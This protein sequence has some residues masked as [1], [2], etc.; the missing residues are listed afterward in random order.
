[1]AEDCDAPL[2]G[3]SAALGLFL[4]IGTLVSYIPQFWIIAKNKSSD[5]INPLAMW[6]NFLSGFLTL[7]N[8]LLLSW[9]DVECCGHT[10]FGHCLARTLPITQLLIGPVC[11]FFLCLFIAMYFDTTA[12]QM[13][14]RRKKVLQRFA[15]WTF[16]WSNVL[17]ILILSYITAWLVLYLS[18]H[19]DGVKGFAYV[20]GLLSSVIIAVV[21]TPQ[22]YT[23][24]K[25]GP[26]M[27]SIWMLALQM[28]GALLVIVFQGII[29]QK[30][31][32]TWAPYVC[33]GI[34]QLIL[35]GL[36]FYYR[37][38][39]PRVFGLKDYEVTTVQEE[40]VALLDPTDDTS[41]E[42]SRYF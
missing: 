7:I 29:N 1:M 38:V 2:K 6:L 31:W 25:K 13:A 39:R 41:P 28:P 21:W 9:E 23:T 32:T 42:G 20:V 19:N 26:G 5:G 40:Q 8:A 35:I 11:L 33:T 12:S 37:C 27:L 30:S 36:W 16:F 18:P 34:Q 14:V 3:E 17:I 4:I 24:W 15:A 22:I 10:N